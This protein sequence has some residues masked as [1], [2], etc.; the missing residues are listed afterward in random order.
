MSRP[1]AE[2]R[3][4]PNCEA[5][6]QYRERLDTSEEA[7]AVE[8]GLTQRLGTRLKDIWMEAHRATQVWESPL[9]FSLHDIRTAMKKLRALLNKGQP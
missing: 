4:D 2:K 1:E 3:P 6:R 8:R 9:N 7:L 5:C